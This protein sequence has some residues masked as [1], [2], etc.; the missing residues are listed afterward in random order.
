MC[1][2]LARKIL[3]GEIRGRVVVDVRQVIVSVPGVIPRIPEEMLVRRARMTALHPPSVAQAP[4]S[5][6]ISKPSGCRSPR[7]GSSRQTPRLLARAKDMHYWTPDGRADPRRHRRP[8]VRQRRP[9]P[10]RDRRGDRRSRRAEMDYAPPFQMGHP[11]GLRAGR[12]PRRRCC[13]ATSTTSS[14]PTP[15]RRRS[16][17]RSRSRSPITARAA[18]ARARGCIGRERGYHGVGFG[19]ISVGGIVDNRK[20]FGALLP[21]VDHLPHTHDLAQQRLHAR[22]ARARR[23]SSPTT[24]ERH[25][26]AARRLDHRRRDRRAGAPARPACWCRPRATSSGCAQI[27]DKHGILL[28]FDEVI[29]GFGRLGTPFARRVLRRHARHDDAS[30]RASPTARCRW[31]PCS[32]ASAIYDAF[33]NGPENAHRALP[34]LHLLGPSARLRRGARPRSTSTRTRTCSSARPSWRRYWEDARALAEG[35]AA[36]SSTSATSA[37]S[38]ASSSQPPRAAVGKRG[39]DAFLKAFERGLLIRTTGDIIAL[40]PPLIIEK[41]QIDEIIDIA[42]QAIKATA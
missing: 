18:R 17:R 12:A 4:L 7:T 28:I 40:S 11:E 1:T 21:G 41:A 34:R 38:A 16:T 22:P 26:R 2:A 10:P 37:W 24:L 25:R 39:F 5:P 36:T 32:C 27:C 30:P 35:P 15:A 6:T 3:K 33:M 14:S 31:A 29:T 9:R 19:G 13:R 42:G 20:C 23:A 8:L